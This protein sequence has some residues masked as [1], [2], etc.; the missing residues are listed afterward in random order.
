LTRSLVDGRGGTH[1]FMPHIQDLTKKDYI[2]FIPDEFLSEGG[3]W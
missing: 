1:T 2:E 3:Y